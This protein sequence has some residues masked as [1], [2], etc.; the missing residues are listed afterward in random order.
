MYGV[1]VETR[2]GAHGEEF[3]VN[4]HDDLTTLEHPKLGPYSDASATARAS[5]ASTRHWRRPSIR[6][7][8]YA[9]VR[10]PDA[11]NH[12]WT[13]TLQLTGE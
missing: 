11:A 2:P 4:C 12:R 5:A 10:R 3:F 9:S 8:C 6:C 1:S 7:T 13:A